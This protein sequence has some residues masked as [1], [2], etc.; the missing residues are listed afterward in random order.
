[1][2]YSS[3]RSRLA[4]AVGLIF[5]WMYLPKETHKSLSGLNVGVWEL[6]LESV[7]DIGRLSD[8]VSE[9]ASHPFFA[10]LP[11]SGS[12]LLPGDENLKVLMFINLWQSW[13]CL[14][15]QFIAPGI[16]E[17]YLLSQSLTSMPFGQFRVDFAFLG[18]FWLFGPYRLFEPFGRWGFFGLVWPFDRSQKMTE[19]DATRYHFC[20]FS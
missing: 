5:S 19:R 16:E 10:F 11:Q 13:L 20:S 1:M 4:E 15:A 14:K 8:S 12:D 9:T 6:R 7:S 17:K 18:K 3:S 2:K